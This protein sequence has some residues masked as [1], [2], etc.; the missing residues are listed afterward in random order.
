MGAPA[1]AAPP[2]LRLAGL[3]VRFSGPVLLGVGALAEPSAAGGGLEW[4]A[5]GIVF[6]VLGAV[7]NAWV[8]LVEILG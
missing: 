5:A 8:L 1:D 7:A 2:P 4:I 3:T 6:A